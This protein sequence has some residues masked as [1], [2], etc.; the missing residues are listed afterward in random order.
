MKSLQILGVR[1]VPAA[2]GG[3]ETFAEK[4]SL[5]LVSR[6]WNVVVYCQEEGRGKVYRS[7]W[8]GVVRVHIPVSGSGVWST[9]KFDFIAAFLA[10]RIGGLCLTLGY[11]TAL[12]NILQRLNG[13]KNIMNMDGV[14]WK[15]AKWGIGAKTW[16]YINEKIGSR[17]SH[18]LIADHPEIKKHLTRNVAS[19]KITMIPYGAE[20][21]NSGSLD[22]L[23]R[24]GLSDKSYS[25]V[26]ARPEPENSILEI[27]KAFSKRVRNHNL[28]VLGKYTNDNYHREVI[29]AA[30]E[31]VLFVGAIY[32]LKVVSSL[33][34]YALSYFHGHQVGGTNPS[35]VEALGAGLP[36]IAHNNRFNRWV[37]GDAAIYFCSEDE[38]DDI[39]TRLLQS[40]EACSSLS[41]SSLKRHGEAF[42]WDDV[43]QSYEE[44]LAYWD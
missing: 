20:K 18:H 42:R 43:L 39:I 1:G 13:C 23:A 16:F 34:Y 27:V 31:E 26:I 40:P 12:F 8:R 25:I 36:I 38:C 15:R 24:Y 32:D 21:L 7:S 17:V 44:L 22:L 41:K 9:M 28:V 4:L 2:H 29:E 11:N 35:L 10:M 33:R 19:D 3:F 30:S 37:A 5:H 6:G 14:E